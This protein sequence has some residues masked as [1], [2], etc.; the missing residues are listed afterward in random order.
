MRFGLHRLG[1]HIGIEQDHSKRIGSAGRASRPCSSAS[2]SALVRPIFRLISERAVQSRSR[3]S[4]RT[5]AS[6]MARIS[7]SALR[8]CCAARTS[9]LWQ[10]HSQ[11]RSC[12]TTGSTKVICN[13]IGP[14][15]PSSN[16]RSLLRVAPNPRTTPCLPLRRGP[17]ASQTTTRSPTV[18]SWSVL[19]LA[20]ATLSVPGLYPSQFQPRRKR[21]SAHRV[22]PVRHAS[23][24]CK[25]RIIAARRLVELCVW[26]ALPGGQGRTGST[27]WST[28]LPNAG[29]L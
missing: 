11:A 16:T 8:L 4:G 19:S 24:C 29:L 18:Q 12:C 10:H 28:N 7:A 1:D 27:S 26:R 22:P 5:A 15:E 3:P 9:P 20:H 23:K 21:R 2:T 6:R 17:A 13:V 14:L 25:T